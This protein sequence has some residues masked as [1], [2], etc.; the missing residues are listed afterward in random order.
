[1]RSPDSS[2]RRSQFIRMFL[3]PMALLLILGIIS[4][5]WL[6]AGRVPGFTVKE[7]QA[8]ALRGSEPPADVLLVGSSR[9]GLAVDDEEVTKTLTNGL[10]AEKIMIISSVESQQSHAIREYF[11]QRGVPKILGIEVSIDKKANADANPKLQYRSTPWI[12]SA[13]GWKTHLSFWRAS[14]RDGLIN[15]TDVF[16]QSVVENPIVTGLARF[17]LGLARGIRE[18]SIVLNPERGCD[19]HYFRMFSNGWAEQI[20]DDYDLPTDSKL[21]GIKASAGRVPDAQIDS[22]RALG[23]FAILNEMVS[24]ARKAG[25]EEVFLMYLPDYAEDPLVMPADRIQQKVPNTP[26]FDTRKFFAESDP[27][28]A[29]QFLDWR[30]LNIYG[31]WAVSRALGTFVSE[32]EANS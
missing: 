19:K 6:E 20:P 31:G 29:N 22:S 32:L 28:I 4:S 13:V 21:E 9:L 23:E 12:R 27:R 3:L 1:M 14:L 7:C 11:S 2:T 18:P 10:K 25:V 24:Y 15:W 26:L 30:H 5:R 17:D 16:V 8:V